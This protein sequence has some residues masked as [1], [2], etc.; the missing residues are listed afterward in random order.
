MYVF[1]TIVFREI[2]TRHT[3]KKALLNPPT[4]PLE[5]FQ[6]F[7]RFGSGTLPLGGPMEVHF[8]KIFRVP[9]DLDLG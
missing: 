3:L 7:I 5:L 6:K 8:V 9:P 2:K 4:P 1:S